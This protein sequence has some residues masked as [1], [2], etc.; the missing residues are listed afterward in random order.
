MSH[1]KFSGTGV[2]IITP[3]N[4]DYSVDFPGLE[5]MV[6]YCIKGKVN[7]IVVLGTTGES[8]TLNK[9]EK[10]EIIDTVIKTVSKRIPIIVG[11]GGNS[12][13][14]VLEGIKTVNLSGIDGILSV[15]P[16]YNKP[17]QN[18]L[19]E[20]YK[21]IAQVSPLPVIMYNVP[22]RTGINMNAETTIKLAR[23]YSNLVAVKEASGNMQQIMEILRDKPA[24]FEVISGDDALTFPMI[25]LGATGVISVV[26]NAF[27][28]D[29]STMVEEA[30]GG[31]YLLAR[32]IHFSLLDI[33]GGLFTEGSPA[34][35]KAILSDMGIVKDIVRLPL[36]P[37]SDKHHAK[38]ADLLAKFNNP[39]S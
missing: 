15:V 14:D 26:A 35:V 10:F 9:K 24:N 3:F 5:R 20:H 21:A 28:A 6:E 11:I 2:A 19:Y 23:D 18:G 38:L 27:P 13:M 4:E 8:V 17:N 36:T 32:K 7:N 16:Y 1:S 25:A 39:E 22:G 34:G 29:F 37:V 30:L 12:T 31:N 33:I